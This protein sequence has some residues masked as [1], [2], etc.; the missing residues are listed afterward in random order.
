MEPCSAEACG[1][2]LYNVMLKGFLLNIALLVYGQMSKRT[3]YTLLLR[4]PF[5]MEHN[6][7]RYIRLTGDESNL[8]TCF[9][10]CRSYQLRTNQPILRMRSQFKE[11]LQA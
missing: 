5:F 9:H 3:V 4:C 7:G 1:F 8:L 11:A 10:E 6:A 2:Q